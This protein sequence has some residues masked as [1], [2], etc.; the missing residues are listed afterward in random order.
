MMNILFLTTILPA[1]KLHGSEIASQTIID[2]LRQAGCRVTVVG[3][4]R[5][6]DG[7][8]QPAES[9]ILV[10]DRYIETQKAKSYPLWWFGVSLVSG[11]PYSAA[12]YKSKRYCQQVQSL[13]QQGHYD[14]V[15]IDHAQ[16]GWLLEVVNGMDGG[17]PVIF[18]SHNIEHEIYLQYVQQ[19]RHPI[20]TWV[21]RREA[22]LVQRMEDHLATVA[23][24]TWALTQH[25]ADYFN[26]L[27]PLGRVRT[28]S[29]PCG[30]ASLQT[31]GLEK[32]YD[33][34]IIGSWSWK[35]NIEGLEWFLQQVYPQL[36][37]QV[38]IQVAGRGVDWLSGRYPNITYRGF[39]PDASV[40]MAQARVVAIPILSG[41]GIQ[42]KTLDAIAAG[43][44][45]VA[46]PMALRGIDDPPSTVSIT[47][48][49][50]TFGRSLMAAIATGAGDEARAEA[51][52]WYEARQQRFR[53]EMAAVVQDL[54]QG[55]A[56]VSC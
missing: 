18:N 20:A 2:G 19:S 39:V 40:F 52:Q 41:G 24:Q 13:L 32:Q 17:R 11:L 29:L 10:A 55:L 49:P 9:E 12:K 23:R 8:A 53:T 42:I 7:P 36:P 1:K 34:G 15:V 6:E 48:E 37:S 21:Y 28:V 25:D 38:S 54:A 4:G 44:L 46:T 31:D 22:K 27:K 43:S 47:A 33:I 5:R 26:R 50:V 45:M 35:P 30:C 51:R 3:Y 56:A 16:L 14:A